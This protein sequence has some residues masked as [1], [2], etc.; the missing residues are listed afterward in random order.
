MEP[1]GPLFAKV[2]D[3][4]WGGYAHNAAP[5]LLNFLGGKLPQD[6]EHRLLDLGCGTGQLAMVFLQAGWNVTGIDLSEDMM[7][8]ARLKTAPYLVSGQAAFQVGD[9]RRFSF[10]TPFDAVV[11][12]YNT[13]NHLDG[14]GL[15]SSLECIHQNLS[16]GGFALLDL[17]TAKGLKEWA[18]SES[19]QTG[20]VLFDLDGA[21]DEKTGQGKVAVTGRFGQEFLDATL[22]NYSHPLEKVEAFCKKLGFSSFHWA[23]P[24]EL[25]KPLAEPEKETR[26]FLVASKK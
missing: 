14:D 17:N 1:Y 23:V 22:V 16:P 2:Y 13:L 12:T 20:E 4:H 18:H 15:A 8:F 5:V 26:V 7:E 21:Y 3:R 25:D 24:T 11:A 9:I 10:E 19:V 6:R